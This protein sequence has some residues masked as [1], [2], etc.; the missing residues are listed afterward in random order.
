[1]VKMMVSANSWRRKLFIMWE[2][3]FFNR[4]TDQGV[5]KVFPSFI[6]TA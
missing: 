6:K 1:M 3:T 4:S 5:G 2:S